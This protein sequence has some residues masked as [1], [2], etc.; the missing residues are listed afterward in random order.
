MNNDE[1]LI[2][3]LNIKEKIETIILKILY[4]CKSVKSLKELTEKTLEKSAQERI[5]TTEKHINL[6]I[7]QMNKDEKIKFTQKD[8]WKIRI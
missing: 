6:I 5:T 1:S 8:G 2:V 4:K 7:N 3:P